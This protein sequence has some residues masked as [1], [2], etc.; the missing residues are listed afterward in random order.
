MGNTYYS[1]VGDPAKMRSSQNGEIPTSMEFSFR[2]MT[3]NAIYIKISKLIIKPTM[4]CE[5]II[6]KKYIDTVHKTVDWFKVHSEQ[7]IKVFLVCELGLPGC[8]WM[9][10]FKQA[11]VHHQLRH[12]ME[13]IGCTL[14]SIYQ[15]DQSIDTS[16]HQ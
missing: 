13:S 3:N 1:L 9:V 14:Q 15:E 5:T 7:N 11:P 4:E 10:S 6:C 2:T 16:I 12:T 8:A